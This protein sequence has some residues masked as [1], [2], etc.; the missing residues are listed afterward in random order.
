MGHVFYNTP[1]LTNISGLSAWNTSRVRHMPQMFQT[2]GVESVDISG[3]DMRSVTSMHNMFLDASSLTELGLGA[4]VNLHP[5][6]ELRRG[7]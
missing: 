3:W 7:I 2:S 6:V 5:T 1:N 4:N